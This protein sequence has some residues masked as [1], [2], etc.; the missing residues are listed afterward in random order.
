MNS[1]PFLDNKLQPLTDAELGDIVRPPHR[2]R[3]IDITN[4]AFVPAT[5]LRRKLEHLLMG[6]ELDSGLPILRDGVLTG[7][8]PAPDLEFALDSLGEQ[9]DNTHCLMAMDASIAVYDSENENVVQEDFTRFIDPVGPC[10]P[11]WQ[12]PSRGA[13]LIDHFR[14][15]RHPF[16]STCIRPSILFINVSPSSV[17]DIYASCRTASMQDWCTRRPL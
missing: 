6:G 2:G 4:S 3:I 17:C 12:T 16:P 7:L 15:D 10:V 1:Y 8:I 13:W 5:E 11:H 9:E 14:P